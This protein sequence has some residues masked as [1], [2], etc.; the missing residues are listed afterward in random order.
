MIIAPY[1]KSYD[2][3]VVLDMP[4]MKFESG[5]IYG[6]AGANGSGK[7][8]YAKYLA[9]IEGAGHMPQKSFAFKLGVLKNVML[10][11]C[12]EK[13]AMEMLGRLGLGEL[14]DKRADKLSGGETEKL[15][16]ARVLS[17]HFDL[18]ILD[19]PTAA[20]DVESTL[21]AEKMIREYAD[22]ENS[23]VVL[24]SHSIGQI[25]RISDEMIF[26][27]K[28]QLIEKGETGSVLASP[29]NELSRQ[30]INF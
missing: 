6:I 12:G 28:G 16:L 7:S 14:A 15:A 10:S 22:R 8:T 26:L 11:G 23:V 18:L 3:R 17:K 2:G 27:H 5:K 30:F 24:I 4:Q 1:A 20:M 13:T 25:S 29:Q 9:G 19:E 21:E